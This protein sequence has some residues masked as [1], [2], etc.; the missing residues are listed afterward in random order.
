MCSQVELFKR[1]KENLS[2]V[3]LSFDIIEDTKLTKGVDYAN[4]ISADTR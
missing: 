2:E 3:H 4:F 1:E